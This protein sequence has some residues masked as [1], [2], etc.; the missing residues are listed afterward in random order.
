MKHIYIG[1]YA[2]F[3]TSNFTTKIDYIIIWPRFSPNAIKE[4]TKKKKRMKWFI[5]FHLIFSVITTAQRVFTCLSV[6]L[7]GE[8]VYVLMFVS[9][10][11]TGTS[12]MRGKRETEKLY[13]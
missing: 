13:T 12:I 11:S 1:I 10:S 7:V 2:G 4:Q 8:C 5:A 3:T 6:Y 9:L